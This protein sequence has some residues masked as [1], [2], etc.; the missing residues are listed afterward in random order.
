MQILY[1]KRFAIPKTFISISYKY[2][3]SNDSNI[4]AFSF[5]QNSAIKGI[6]F[7]INV[8]IGDSNRKISEIT[9]DSHSNN[10]IMLSKSNNISIESN[11][12][13]NVQTKYMN[14]LKQRLG[15]STPLASFLSG[16]EK[17][18]DSKLLNR[19]KAIPMPTEMKNPTRWLLKQGFGDVLDYTQ[20]RTI[21][22][23]LISQ[24]ESTNP[25]NEILQQL[26]EQLSSTN[27]LTSQ[28]VTDD[29]KLDE[30]IQKMGLH[31]HVILFVSCDD[32]L[33]QIAK[34]KMFQLCRYRPSNALFGHM[35]TD[36][37]AT[38]P[39]ELQDVI[40]ERNGIAFRSSVFQSRLF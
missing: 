18:S 19:A 21:K 13:A 35:I 23:G 1:C 15:E 27:F 39:L 40:E 30:I 17:E 6:I 16:F 25:K 11:P 36:Y 4:S 9:K 33:L 37:I 26:Q 8:L 3:H 32:N 29:E 7:D 34:S 24:N 31:S 14:K 38:N 5:T 20:G 28:H 10:T 2:I 12:L 22:L